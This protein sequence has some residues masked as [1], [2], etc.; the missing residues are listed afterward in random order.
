LGFEVTVIG[1]MDAIMNMQVDASSGHLLQKV[2]E[3]KN[4][5]FKLGAIT[6]KIVGKDKVESLEFEDGTTLNSRFKP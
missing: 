1:N 3:Q 6:T 5:H 4:I 2:L